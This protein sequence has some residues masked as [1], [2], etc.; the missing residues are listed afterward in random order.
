MKKK[1]RCCGD[2]K[3]LINVDRDQ[4]KL[5]TSTSPIQ[6]PVDIINRTYLDY[7]FTYSSQNIK[8]L[9]KNNAPPPKSHVPY[10]ILN[11]VFRI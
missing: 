6:P 1:N 5:E 9:P 2:K 3:V 10:Y 8:E 11:R 4:K 7:T